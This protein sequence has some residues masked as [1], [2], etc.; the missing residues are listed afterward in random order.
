MLRLVP[1]DVL[2]RR[3]PTVRRF[4][5][6]TEPATESYV[7]TRLVARDR[8]F[9]FAVGAFR[10][11]CPNVERDSRGADEEKPFSILLCKFPSLR[12]RRL[13]VGSCG[14][15]VRIIVVAIKETHEA[16]ACHM[17]GERS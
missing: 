3:S 9:K 8:Q 2:Q 14:D 13:G 12:K 15:E 16:G 10:R 5:V 6:A 17:S 11:G 7:G 1:V 4:E